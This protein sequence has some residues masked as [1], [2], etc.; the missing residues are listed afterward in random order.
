MTTETTP[1]R[2]A[3]SRPRGTGIL[4]AAALAASGSGVVLAVVGG[5]VSGSAAALGAVVG[6]GLAVAVFALGSFSVDVVAGQLP[7]ASLLVA[8]L[9]YTLQ[10]ALMWLALVALSRSGLLGGALADTWLVAG[11]IAATAVWLGA[12]LLLATRAR[13]PAYDLPDPD[14]TPRGVV[15]DSPEAG[16]R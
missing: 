10:V 3:R 5:A 6:T 9:T 2:R 14:E 11:V 13:I 16:A 1:A 4:V 7:A 12:Q 15:G 8:V